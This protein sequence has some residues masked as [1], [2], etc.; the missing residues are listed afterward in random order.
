M[1]SVMMLFIM[2]ISTDQASPMAIQAA[3]RLGEALAQ[4][5]KRR[6]LTQDD[7]AQQA[8]LSKPTVQR[9]EQGSAQIGL[10][11]LLDILDV[12]DPSLLDAMVQVIEADLP[13]Q[14]LT[15]QQLPQRVRRSRRGF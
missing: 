9:L 13:G 10:G 11:Y 8:S 1:T 15:T 14:A 3:T 7:L 5:R 6:G 2:K 12:L 4:A